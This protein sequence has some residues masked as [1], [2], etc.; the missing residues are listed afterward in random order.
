V[1]SEPDYSV[2]LRAL[3]AEVPGFTFTERDFSPAEL[4]AWWQG[5]DAYAL[6]SFGEGLSLTPREAAMRA[7]PSVLSEIEAHQELINHGWAIGVSHRDEEIAH[8]LIRVH[9]NDL[10]TPH[11]LQPRSWKTVASEIARVPETVFYWCQMSAR[12]GIAEYVRHLKSA[13]LNAADCGSTVQIG[14]AKHAVFVLMPGYGDKIHQLQASIQRLRKAGTRVTLDIHHFNRGNAFSSL[15]AM[16]DDVI[17]HHPRAPVEAGVGRYVPLPVPSVEQL[18]IR[19]LGGLV[20]FGIWAPNKR[21]DVMARLAERLNTHL[22]IYGHNNAQAV[23]TLP[24]HLRPRIYVEDSFPDEARLA[25]LLRQH[26]VGL[27]GRAPWPNQ[28]PEL[29][30][31]ASPRFFVAAGV[32]AVIDVADPHED[33][34]GALDVVSYADFETLAARVARLMN[35][36]DYRALALERAKAYASRASPS[37]VAKAMRIAV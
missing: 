22:Y 25:L 17:W 30:G 2:A 1:L 10:P 26:S 11:P 31:A 4:E 32:P 36:A 16:V 21:L 23:A 20:H 24:A 7:L 29:H 18:P 5:L 12:C 27:I 35:D 19:F 14:R 37:E 13:A 9:D 3:A 33:L 15:Y 6:T 28:G 8:A 34:V